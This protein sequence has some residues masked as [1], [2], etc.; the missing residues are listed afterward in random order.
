MN[1]N[2]ITSSKFPIKSSKKITKRFDTAEDCIASDE[3][4]SIFGGVVAD[5]DRKALRKAEANGTLISMFAV[6]GVD[7]GRPILY[8]LIKI[9]VDCRPSTYNLHQLTSV[10]MC[11]SVPVQLVSVEKDV[12]NYYKAFVDKDKLETLGKSLSRSGEHMIIT[13]Q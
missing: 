4:N 7:C 11:S 13:E 8:K 10:G 12:V 6:E 3:W 2:F 1:N 5:Y 9:E